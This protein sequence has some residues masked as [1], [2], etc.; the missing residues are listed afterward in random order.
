MQEQQGPERRV[1]GEV[2]DAVE[3]GLAEAALPLGAEGP[4]QRGRAPALGDAPTLKDLP[5]QLGRGRPGHAPDPGDPADTGVDGGG[6]TDPLGIAGVR[7]ERGHVVAGVVD[8]P[9]EVQGGGRHP[10]GLELAE[11]HQDPRPPVRGQVH[12]VV[13]L[14]NAREDDVHQPL[15][16]PP[17]LPG[18]EPVTPFLTG[19]AM[20]GCRV[21]AA[22]SSCLRDDGSDLVDV[23]HNRAGPPGGR[24]VEAPDLA[25]V[26]AVGAKT[27][28]G[29][30]R[31]RKSTMMLE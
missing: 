6:R 28:I 19:L 31:G 25:V 23:G 8:G 13:A 26:G 24:L 18:A 21:G 29:R 2:D 20:A 11:V 5:G 17:V 4:S 7:V 10:V 16:G 15:A 14:A 1:P 22:T 9:Q 30:S 12:E 27:T 3:L